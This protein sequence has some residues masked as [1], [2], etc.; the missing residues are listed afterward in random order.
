MGVGG[1]IIFGADA[2]RALGV[3]E[4]NWGTWPNPCFLGRLLSNG[5][6]V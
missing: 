1:Y 6:P 4:M 5:K 3:P 2:F